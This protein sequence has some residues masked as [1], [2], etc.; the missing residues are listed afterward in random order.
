MTF[1]LALNRADRLTVASPD[2]IA[3]VLIGILLL[4]E[5]VRHAAEILLYRGDRS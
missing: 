1:R 4:S 5:M 3:H 2:V